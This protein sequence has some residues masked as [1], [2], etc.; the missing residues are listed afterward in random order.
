MQENTLHFGE[1]FI[2]IPL[3]NKTLIMELK[4]NSH[5]L[6]NSFT[7]SSVYENGRRIM[8]KPSIEVSMKI[9]VN[10]NEN[11]YFLA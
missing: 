3:H 11:K 2:S 9:F 10:F 5:L 4:L 6:S 7:T 1:M 8:Y